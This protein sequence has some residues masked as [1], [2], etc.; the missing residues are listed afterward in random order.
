MTGNNFRY[1]RLLSKM[2]QEELAFKIGVGKMTVSNYEIGKR[3]PDYATLQRLSKVLGVSLPKLL[4]HSNDNLVISHGA[5]RRQSGITKSRQDI[6][7]WE[8]DR[9]LNKLYEVF[10]YVDG[11]GQVSL[12]LPGKQIE[13]KGSEEDAQKLRRAMKLPQTGPI[14]NITDI[15][16]NNGFIICPVEIDGRDFSGNSGSVNGRPYIAVNTAM[17]AERQRFTLVH[18]LSH[19]FFKFDERQDEEKIVDGIAGAFLLPEQDI[20][21]ELGPKRKD[22]RGNLRDL[23]REYGISMASVAMRAR[24]SDIISQSIYEST[25]KWMSVNGLRRDENSGL[26]V[27]KTH[28]LEQLVSRAVS[29]EEISLS[30]AAELLEMPL[31]DVRRLCYGGM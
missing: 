3:K 21:R 31:T 10:S 14:G 22:I 19:L 16:E 13:A 4:A 12:K 30:K 11:Q 8:I 5:F 15:L 17:S 18:E 29:E 2:S 26:E 20:I 9:Y 1:Y 23:Q 28:L 6:I 25:M 24:Q 27:E 7:L